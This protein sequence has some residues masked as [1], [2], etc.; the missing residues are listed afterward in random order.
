V[1]S[2]GLLICCVLSFSS[3]RYCLRHREHASFSVCCLWNSFAFLS[4]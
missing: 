3:R 1:W 2:K 4:L